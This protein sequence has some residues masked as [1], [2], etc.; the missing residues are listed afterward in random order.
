[1]KTRTWILLLGALAATGCGD[2]ASDPG[3]GAHFEP[4]APALLSTG[5]PTK[6]EDPSVLLARDG[7]MYVAWFSD[8]DDGAGDI[9]VAR[10]T[11][12]TSWT[13][14]RRVTTS[15]LGDFYP[16]LIQDDAGTFH[17]TWFRW[18]TL[19]RGYIM[20]ST[21]SD[22]LAWNVANEE[23]VTTDTDVDDWLPTPVFTSNGTM[24][25]YFVSE[26]RDD[27]NPTSEIYVTSKGPSD[28]DWSV[29]GPLLDI[30][31]AS[32]HDQL[33]FVARTGANLTIVWVR[34][35]TTEPKPWLNAKSQLFA[36]VSSDGLSW[37]P[38]LQITHDVGNVVHLFPSLYTTGAGSAWRVLWLST[39]SGVPK[40]YELPI[41]SLDEYP[42]D[43]VENT[44]LPDIGYS[45]RVSRTSTSGVYL[46]AWVQGPVN[47]EDVYYRFFER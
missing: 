5:S 25:I 26:L 4:T 6:D 30:N 24:R 40:V 38:P 27:T 11:A 23:S 47:A 21:S 10:M 32:E 16:S 45:H 19:E 31:S 3:A 9:Y 13:G 41:T 12:G 44:E 37:S 28:D 33:P 35:D 42:D 36:A 2:D 14:A 20:H 18:Y 7:S 34:H 46:G 43:V 1:V 22:G 15:P 29:P 8:R 17:L 39:R